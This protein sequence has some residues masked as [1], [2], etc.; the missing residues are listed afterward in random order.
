MT[1]AIIEAGGK[2]IW[3]QLGQFYD[4]NY[5]HGDPGDSIYFNRVLFLKDKDDIQIGMPCL[6]KVKIK[7][8]ILRHFKGRKIIVFKMK[9]KKNMRSKS[10]HRQKLTRLLIEEIVR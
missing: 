7:A 3:I 8:K 6:Q 2:Q 10:G 5:I 9:P 4:I 1:Y